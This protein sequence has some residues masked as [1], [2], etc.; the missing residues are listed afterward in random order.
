MFMAM[1]AAR[2]SAGAEIKTSGNAERET[3]SFSELDLELFS[4]ASGDRNPLHLSREYAR[5]TP[6]GQ[7]V[8][9]G[10]LGALACLRNARFL[11]SQTVTSLR[12][13]FLRPMF[14]GVKYRVEQSAGDGASTACLYDGSLPVVSVAVNSIPGEDVPLNPVGC[15]AYFE[16]QAAAIREFQT[17]EPGLHVSGDYS[18]D[19]EAFSALTERWEAPKPVLTAALAW[20]SFLVG[21][22]FPGESALFS[23]LDLT[24]PP[25][26]CAGERL[27]YEATAASVDKR[28]GQVRINVSVA[29]GG[30]KLFTG[31][32]SSYVRPD[33]PSLDDEAIPESKEEAL[34]GRTAVVIGGSRG[35]GASILR[36]ME[37]RGATVYSLARSAANTLARRQESGDAADL[38]ALQSLRDRVIE[39][40]GRLDYL[41]CN[42]C[43][44]VLP[45]RLEPN[46]A[47]RI[48][49]FV[50]EAVS[51]TLAPLCSFLELLNASGGCLVIISSSAVESPVREWPHYLAAKQA[52]EMLARVASLQ[53]PKIRTLI[54]RPPKLLTALTNT[55][56]GRLGAVPPESFAGRLVDRLEAPM[57]SGKLEIVC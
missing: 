56:M 27:A 53:Y 11:E 35:L 40:E 22:E 48:A 13:E 8:V 41:V 36:T 5:R 23:K 47:Q 45:L 2:D 17:I 26:S 4:K 9:F 52:V 29:F 12:A 54:V 6:Y 18:P 15:H 14:L 34:A 32:L 24:F 57:E 10:C 21:M 37:R 39:E 51:L 50:H 3:V 46:A 55:P 25:G 1:K 44:P 43:P 42:A 16:R 49:T 33:L 31:Q 7:P 30:C 19:P 28:F 38:Q 20:S